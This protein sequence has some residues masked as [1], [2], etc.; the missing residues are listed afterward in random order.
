MQIY[1][2]QIVAIATF[3]AILSL[4]MGVADADV[5]DLLGFVF[6]WLHREFDEGRYAANQFK[7]WLAHS[8]REY[9]WDGGRFG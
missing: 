4:Q 5:L 1:Y 8:S 3:C 6:G 2:H 7:G 9:G